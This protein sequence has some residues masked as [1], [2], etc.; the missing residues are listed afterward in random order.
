M[1]NICKNC[2]KE[3]TPDPNDGKCPECGS[4]KGYT[5]SQ[6][7]TIKWKIEDEKA[8]IQ[9]AIDEKFKEYNKFISQGNKV[10]FYKNLKELLLKEIPSFLEQA[11]K[12]AKERM[13]KEEA[14]RKQHQVSFTADVI[15]GTEEQRKIKEQED[16]IQKLEKEKNELQAKLFVQQKIDEG[17]RKTIETM[18][19]KTEKIHG[20]L[21]PKTTITLALIIGITASFLGSF[22][23][24]QIF[25]P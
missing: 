8:E 4:K 17:F 9:K 21:S 24:A 13:E 2:S 25:A 23:Y 3:V 5:V 16:F 11:E 22:I 12:N 10:E 18:A 19:D 6:T 20:L 1:T 14:E 15:V 7:F